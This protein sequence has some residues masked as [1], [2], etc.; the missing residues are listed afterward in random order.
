[1]QDNDAPLIYKPL[2]GN[3][4]FYNACPVNFSLILRARENKKDIKQ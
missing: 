4:C 2:A 1:M 3:H